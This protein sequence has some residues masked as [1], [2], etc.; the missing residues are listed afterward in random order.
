MMGCKRIHVGQ[1]GGVIKSYVINDFKYV[2]KLWINLFS[3]TSAL[4]RG[5]SLSN[6]GTIM[7]ITKNGDFL[8]FGQVLPTSSG[9][10]TG[11]L[12]QP[13][14][15]THAHVGVDVPNQEDVPNAQDTV[16]TPNPIVEAPTVAAQVPKRPMVTRDVNDLH[17]MFG[18]AH[19]IKQSAKYYNIKLKGDFKTC[20]AWALEKIR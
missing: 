18:H 15:I 1:P 9:A 17:H 6:N 12:M 19:A 11:V 16:E 10:I 5:W 4:R 8:V 13:H 3:V 20:V 14:I 7:S 2:P